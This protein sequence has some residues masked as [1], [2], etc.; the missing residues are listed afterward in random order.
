M[1]VWFYRNPI[2][3]IVKGYDTEAEAFDVAKEFSDGELAGD[4]PEFHV[5]RIDN[6]AY[7]GICE[8]EAMLGGFPNCYNPFKGRHTCVKYKKHCGNDPA[9]CPGDCGDVQC[10]TCDGC[11]LSKLEMAYDTHYMC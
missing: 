4:I 2:T 10:R 9:V 3:N 8:N 11:V 5:F 6:C 7:S 1:T